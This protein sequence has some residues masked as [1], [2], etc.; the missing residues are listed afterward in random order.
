MIW[1]ILQAALCVI[2]GAALGYAYGRFEDSQKRVYQYDYD[3]PSDFPF[4]SPVGERTRRGPCRIY[5]NRWW[6]RTK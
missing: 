5:G 4:K 6:R 1:E 2:G 3:Y